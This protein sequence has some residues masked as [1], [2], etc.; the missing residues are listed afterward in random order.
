M[1]AP[2]PRFIS[3]RARDGVELAFA[4][5]L[6]PG[7]GPFPTL[8]AASPYR[9]D[10]NSLP[11][12]PQFLW[13][14]TGPIAFYL[15]QGYAFVHMDARGCGRT[16]GDFEFLGPKEQT[17]LFDAISFVA[18][19]SWCN[20]R[21]GSV[22]QS[23]F[24]MLQWFMA[25]QAP[26]GLVCVGAHDGLNDPYRAAAYHGGIPCDFFASYW[27]NQ[28][29]AINAHPASGPPRMQEPDLNRMLAE[30]PTLDAF[31]RVRSASERLDQI[32]LPL[33][34]SGVWTKMQLHTRGNI[35]GFRKARGPK[36]LRMSGVPNAFA[37][38]DEFNSVAFHEK[39]MLPF[40]DH[41]LK[42]VR[43]DYVNRPAIE[44]AV[45]GSGLTRQAEEWPP[46]GTRFRRWHLAPG[47]SGSVTS[48]NDGLL[49]ETP[50]EGANTTSYDYPQPGWVNGVVG[51][52]GSGPAGGFDPARRVLT[53]VSEPLAAD[54]EICGPL[55]LELFASSTCTD[56]DFFIKVT[57]QF[58]QGAEAR[59]AG[60]SPAAEIVSRGWLRASHRKLDFTRSTDIEPVHTFD[61]PQ[62]LTPGEVTRFDISIEPMA[63]LFKVG[64]RI[65]LELVNG[66]SG[67][68]E[69]LWTHFYTPNKIGRDT[70]H[71]SAACPSCL[72]LPVSRPSGS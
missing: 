58:P 25:I 23:Y 27:W 69:A 8:F 53:F 42:G 2:E 3:T 68:T 29:R 67:L 19:Q 43:T 45:R 14:E 60:V 64:H 6:P 49:L 41:Y 50:N 70:I 44:Y 17:D 4:L 38:A 18:Q 37:A 54:L 34:S 65:R 57:D 1:K 10:N 7:D 61:D 52:G 32:R 72:I 16:G 20:G 5:Y 13:R 55:K 12:G 15:E 48:L 28:N 26:P 36:K 31:W 21:V 24:C 11:H 59:A 33:Y 30:H 39:V 62:P 66:D 63:Y 46:A 22:G 47:P 51:F 40:Y 56:T 35:E 71:H 9:F